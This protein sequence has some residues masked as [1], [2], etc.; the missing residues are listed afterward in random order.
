[1]SADL[2]GVHGQREDL[3]RRLRDLQVAGDAAIV[4][5]R[6]GRERAL[7]RT[8]LDEAELWLSRCSL[9]DGS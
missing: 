6:T 7:F 9:R 8:K 3:L 1:M 2:F 5:E 4:A